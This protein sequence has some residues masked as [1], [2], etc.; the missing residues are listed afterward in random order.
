MVHWLIHLSGQRPMVPCVAPQVL[1][2]ELQLLFQLLLQWVH[3]SSTTKHLK[4]TDRMEHASIW[5][6]CVFIWARLWRKMCGK[7]NRKLHSERGRL[8]NLLPSAGWGMHWHSSSCWKTKYERWLWATKLN[9]RDSQMMLPGFSWTGHK[10]RAP[11]KGCHQQTWQ[12]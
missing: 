11:A 7:Q 12:T 8:L 5:M 3:L 9:L 4:Q 1:G 10:E 2:A 6:G